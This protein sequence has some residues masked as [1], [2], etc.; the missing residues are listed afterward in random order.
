MDGKCLIRDNVGIDDFSVLGFGVKV[1]ANSKI[2]NAKIYP[3]IAIQE[4]STIHGDLKN[5]TTPS[6]KEMVE[7][8]YW[9]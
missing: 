6:T 9:L 2:T 1:G 3:G 8:T 7:S 4:N 5:E